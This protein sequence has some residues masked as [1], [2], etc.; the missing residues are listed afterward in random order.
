[1]REGYVL[2]KV[3]ADSLG[4][5]N[6]TPYYRRGQALFET[7]DITLSTL[8]TRNRFPVLSRLASHYRGN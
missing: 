4:P 7:D 2:S 6:L 1:M 5:S 3:F 8:V